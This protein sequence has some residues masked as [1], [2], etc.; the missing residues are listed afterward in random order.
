VPPPFASEAAALLACGA[1]AVLSHRTAAW[2]WGIVDEHPERVDVTIPG[3]ARAQRKGIRVHSTSELER[4]EIR[5][6]EGMPFTAPARTLLDLAAVIGRRQLR[7]ALEEARGH[8]I[9]RNRDLLPLL[10]RFPRR[11]GTRALRALL[12]EDRPPAITRSEAERRMLELI[13][14]AE[15][16]SPAV[17]VEVAGHRVDLYWPEQRLVVE[18]N[19]YAYHSRPADFERDRRREQDLAAAGMRV[20][21]VTWRQL[22]ERPEAVVARLAGALALVL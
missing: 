18:V 5:I 12:A 14:R 17:N 9:V 3:R 13:E 8:R 15:L 20:S 21:R 1:D 16:P 6:R 11:R 4:R 10:A 7:W 2:F 22:V 19:G